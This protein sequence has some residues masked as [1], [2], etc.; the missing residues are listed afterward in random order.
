MIERIDPQLFTWSR[1]R[2]GTPAD[3]G[4][5]ARKKVLISNKER[6]KQYSVGYCNGENLVCRPKAETKAVMFFKDGIHFWFHFKNEE[7]REIYET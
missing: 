2:A 4:I 1:W 5:V 7:F 3:L 6:L